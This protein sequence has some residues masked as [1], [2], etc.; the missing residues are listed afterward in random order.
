DS[1]AIGILEAA[2]IDFVDNGILPPLG[3]EHRLRQQQAGHQSHHPPQRAQLPYLHEYIALDSGASGAHSTPSAALWLKAPRVNTSAKPLVSFWDIW[4][5]CF[6]FLGL[7]F[8]F[9]L[10][11]ANVS[12]IFQTLGAGP[13]QMPLLWIA[14]PFSGLIVQPIVGYLS[15]RTWTR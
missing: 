12:R 8:G 14:A 1:V 15:D 13:D 5:M 3:R 2:G 4:N 9:A 7:Q 10:Q 6:G 11:N